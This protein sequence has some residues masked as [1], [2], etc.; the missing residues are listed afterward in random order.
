[1]AG[2]EAGSCPPPEEEQNLRGRKE[3]R[4]RMARQAGS[5]AGLGKQGAGH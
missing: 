1:M 2:S 5:W 4:P 3:E